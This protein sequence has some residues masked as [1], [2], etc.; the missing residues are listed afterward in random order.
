MSQF[1]AGAQLDFDN[2]PDEFLEI[3]PRMSQSPAGVQLDFDAAAFFIWPTTFL[4]NVAIPCRAQLDS[5]D[6][7]T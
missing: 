2:L 6:G 1:P 4:L 3:A 7:D 5:D